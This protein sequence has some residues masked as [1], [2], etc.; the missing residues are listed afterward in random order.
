MKISKVEALSACSL[1]QEGP[2]PGKN[3]F[4]ALTKRVF[5]AR[6]EKGTIKKDNLYTSVLVISD[7]VSLT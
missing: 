3:R 2:I 1:K 6:T 7:S 4:A 5:T